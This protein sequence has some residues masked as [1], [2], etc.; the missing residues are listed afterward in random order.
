MNPMLT[1]VKARV[2]NQR[3]DAIL[4]VQY[5]Y[6]TATTTSQSFSSLKAEIQLRFLLHIPYLL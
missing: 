1:T 2:D 4:Y 6:T 3:W 5:Y